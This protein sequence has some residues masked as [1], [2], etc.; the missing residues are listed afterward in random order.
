MLAAAIGVLVSFALESVASR[1]LPSSAMALLRGPHQANEALVRW[2]T[3]RLFGLGS[4][5]E[6]V[7][8][9]T[10]KDEWNGRMNYIKTVVKEAVQEAEWRLPQIYLL[11]KR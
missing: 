5:K 1:V 6:G 7:V 2:V 8:E 11:S 3:S 4:R 10:P 9:D